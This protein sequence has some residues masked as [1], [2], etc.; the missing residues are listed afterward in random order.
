MT[1]LASR[2]LR[3]TRAW[4]QLG[5]A[6]WPVPLGLF[7]LALAARLWAASETPFAVNE[8]SA[9]YVG[10]SRNLVEGEGW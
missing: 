2:A 9:S 7:G 8:G 6:T 1:V 4:D 10:V 3:Q 5:L